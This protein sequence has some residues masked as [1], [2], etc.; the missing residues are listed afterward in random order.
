LERHHRLPGGQG[1]V[2]R[3]PARLLELAVSRDAVLRA[4]A[5]YTL[6]RRAP[7]AAALQI[8]EEGTVSERVMEKV[9]LLEGVGIFERCSVDDLAALAA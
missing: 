5:I 9:F 2:E 3:A 7:E 4:C 1:E 6:R 8:V